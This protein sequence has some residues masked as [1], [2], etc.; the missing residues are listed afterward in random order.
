M[1]QLEFNFNT[2]EGTC[3]VCGNP[4]P[5]DRL[6]EGYTVCEDCMDYNI[7]DD[8][9]YP[10]DNRNRGNIMT[11]VN[12]HIEDILAEVPPDETFLPP[13]VISTVPCKKLSISQGMGSKAPVPQKETCCDR[14]R[15]LFKLCQRCGK[16]L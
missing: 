15:G 4:L 14:Y 1:R 2:E 6:I 7:S 11:T 12:N 3:P 13:K 16:T 9:T 10:N 8:N 5:I